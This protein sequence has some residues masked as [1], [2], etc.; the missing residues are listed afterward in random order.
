MRKTG[1]IYLAS[2]LLLAAMAIPAAAQLSPTGK[3]ATQ[4]G[5][6]FGQWIEVTYSRP[7]LRGRRGILAEGDS[8]G[9]RVYAG[10]PVW[11]A[12]AD[13]STRLRTE[14]DLMFGT[15][16]LSAG[17]YSLFI[18]LKA[19]DSWELIVS[20]HEPKLTPNRDDDGKVWGALRVRRFAGRVPPA[21]DGG[22]AD[23]FRDGPADLVLHRCQRGWWHPQH[24][25]GQYDR[26]GRL[27]GRQLDG[28]SYIKA[29]RP[30]CARPNISA[31]ISWVPS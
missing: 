27:Y 7:I 15:N 6:G 25:L 30:V 17:E 11:R 28:T 2:A 21:D 31:W 18:E 26:A 20:N 8:Y 16:K 13:V 29:C 9:Q 3:A 10:A 14:A 24:H 23:R 22:S 4:V 1:I 5:A 19:A 12:G